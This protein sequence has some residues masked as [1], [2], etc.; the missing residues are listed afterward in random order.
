[1]HADQRGDGPEVDVAYHDERLAA[2]YDVLNKWTPADDDDVMAAFYLEYVM[3]AASVLDVG[4]GTGELLCRAR[5]AGHGGDL[6]GVDPASGM[7]AIARRKRGD[8][9]WLPG[10]AESL[11]LGRTFELITMTG[12]AFQE[13]LDDDRTRAAFAGFRRHLAPGGR[14]VFETRNPAARAWECWTPARTT[15]TVRSPAGQAFDVSYDVRGTRA[16][17]LV[18]YAASFRSWVSGETV[19]SLGTIRFVNP[20]HLR[21]LL[22]GAG[23]RVDGWYGDWD[24]SGLGAGSPEVIVVATRP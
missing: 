8:I 13:L 22:A 21:S 6:V 24:R 18:D 11:D 17:D 4:C 3:S 2:L 1:V 15:T 16:A 7:L 19:T 10:R 12:H 9:R 20:D 5:R 23:F 14:L